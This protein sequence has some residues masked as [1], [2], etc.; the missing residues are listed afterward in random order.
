MVA[1]EEEQVPKCQDLLD[2]GES[3]DP[4]KMT[5]SRMALIERGPGSWQ[6]GRK[7]MNE[8][9]IHFCNLCGQHEPAP[10]RA[11]GEQR[12]PPPRPVRAATTESK[13]KRHMVL[14]TVRM[15]KVCLRTR[16]SIEHS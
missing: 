11:A 14:R 16:Q 13:T 2:Y 1:H 10:A 7:I 5:Y 9:S 12:L 4:V 3:E 6:L 8:I 15:T